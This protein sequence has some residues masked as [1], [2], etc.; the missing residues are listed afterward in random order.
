MI[1][2][3]K[4]L[5]VPCSTVTTTSVSVQV[6]VDNSGTDTVNKQTGQ[7]VQ[8]SAQNQ[9][10]PATLRAGL[11]PDGSWRWVEAQTDRSGSC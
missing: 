2:A 6:C 8:A 11:F 5:K 9:R 7:S 4:E 10:Y 1:A 3:V